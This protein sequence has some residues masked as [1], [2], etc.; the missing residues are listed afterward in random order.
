MGPKTALIH[1]GTP[2]TGTTSIQQCLANGQANGS[3]GPVCYPLWRGELNNQR[4]AMLYRPHADLPRW[5]RAAY[6]ADDSRFD[7]MRREYAVFI[8]GQLRSAAGAILSAETLSAQFTATN[9]RA[10]RNDLESLGFRRFHVLLYVRDPADYYLSMT[11]QWLKSTA[12]PPFVKDPATF[13]YEFRECSEAWELAFP[14]SLIVRK[15]PTGM[16]DVL[17]DF[18]DVLKEKM[19]VSIPHLP[20]RM[21]T[22]ISAEAMQIL[23]DYRQTYWPDNDGFLTDDIGALVEFLQR[24]TDALPQT[25]PTL[26]HQ[27]VEQIRAKHASD[28]DVVRTRYGVDLGLRS[29]S[30]PEQPEP[31]CGGYRVADII[32]SVDQE[33]VYQLLL[34]LASNE[35]GRNRQSRFLPVRIASRMLRGIPRQRRLKPLKPS[36][37]RSPKGEH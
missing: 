9:A 27:V 1:I 22:T 13:I 17:E 34:R 7:E 21:N 5:M 6:P 18:A 36:C 3:L 31:P 24:S 29:E 35:L 14:G 19:G 32:E 2:K 30:A 15:Y 20:M 23:Q 4:L 28:A 12:E 26:K 10:L 37:G 8:F 16:H 11:S 33:I 25:R